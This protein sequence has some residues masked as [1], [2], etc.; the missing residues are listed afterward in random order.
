MDYWL[1]IVLI[2]IAI[3]AATVSYHLQ[4]Y[5]VEAAARRFSA[6]PSEDLRIASRPSRRNNRLL[7]LFRIGAWC[8]VTS[9]LCYEQADNE[10]VRD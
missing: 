5:R 7:V 1:F 6:V 2:S 8:V 3:G 4:P 10:M 9:K